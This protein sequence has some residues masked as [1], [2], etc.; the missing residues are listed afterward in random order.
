MKWIKLFEDYKLMSIDLDYV[1]NM[2]NVDKDKIKINEDGSIDIDDSVFLNGSEIKKI[3]F[4]F[5]KVSGNFECYGCRLTSLEGSPREVGGDFKCNNN[6]LVN[7]KYSPIEVGRNFDCS[8][9]NLKSVEGMS[10]EIGGNFYCYYNINLRELNSISNIN[11]KVFSD[12]NLD[13]SKFGGYYKEI[14][15]GV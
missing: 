10:V 13:T 8:D 14:I 15:K 4:K 7:L 5:G 3:P 6:R 1:S 2:I 9:N 11:G 12:K